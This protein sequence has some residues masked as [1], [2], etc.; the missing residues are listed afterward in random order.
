MTKLL[1]KMQR[2]A[3]YWKKTVFDKKCSKIVIDDIGAARLTFC[4]RRDLFFGTS[5]F[6]VSGT[7]EQ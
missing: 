1:R 5:F 6:F 4:K 3:L 7:D 2:S